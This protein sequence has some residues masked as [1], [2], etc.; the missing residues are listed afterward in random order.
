MRSHPSCWNKTLAQLGFRRKRRKA[1]SKRDYLKRRSLFEQLEARQMLSG[2]PLLDLSSDETVAAAGIGADNTVVF[3]S[4]PEF[5]LVEREYTREELG[6]DLQE[7]LIPMFVVETE[8]TQSGPKA[9]L[10]FNPAYPGTPP[11]TLQE[12]TLE[13]REF[14]N[15][16]E[17]YD[18]LIDIAEETFREQF[19]ADR[20]AIH[21]TDVEKVDTQEKASWL[22]ER[23]ANLEVASQA[24]GAEYSE[25]QQA[26]LDEYIMPGKEF[27]GPWTSDMHEA[28]DKWTALEANSPEQRTNPSV[29]LLASLAKRQVENSDVLIDDAERER[30]YDELEKQTQT[31]KQER[32]DAQDASALEAVAA[33]EATLRSTTLLIAK[34]LGADLKSENAKVATAAKK[35]RDELVA[36]NDPAEIAFAG[37]GVDQEVERKYISDGEKAV[38][39]VETGRYQF[40]DQLEIDLGD[41]QAM[42]QVTRSWNS[43]LSPLTSVSEA[44]AVEDGSYD[45]SSPSTN[46]GVDTSLHV[47]GTLGALQETLIRFGLDDFANPTTIADA[48]LQLS[49]IG[50]GTG[51]AEVYVWNGLFDGP[52]GGVTDWGE[53]NVSWNHIDGTLDLENS[54]SEFTQLS[55]WTAGTTTEVDVSTQL[56]RALLYGD[57]NG[58]G[59]FSAAGTDGDIEAFHLAVTNWDAYVAEYG[60]HANSASDLL[61]RTDGG[62]GDG[63]V[64]TSDIT[65]FFRRHGYSQGDY[66]L[67]GTVQDNENTGID[68]YDWA[69]WNANYGLTN[70]KFTQ[71]DGNFDGVVDA[72]DYDIWFDR[73]GE[74]NLTP[75]IPEVTVW[76]RPEDT[77]TDIEFAAQE[78][79]TLDGPTLV[80]NE[81]PDLALNKFSVDGSNLV[82]DYAVLGETFTDVKVQLYKVG[83]P[84]TLLHET[85]VQSGALG[86][87][88]VLISTS[89]LASIVEGDSVYAKVVGTPSSGTQANTAND[90]FDFEFSTASTQTVNSLDDVGM[91][92]LLRDQHTLRELILADNALGWF[93]TITFDADLFAEGTGTIALGDQDGNGINDQIKIA[94]DIIITGPGNHLLTIDSRQSS[95]AFYITDNNSSQLR[96]VTI[97]DLSITGGS[98]VGSGGALYNYENFTLDNINLHNNQAANVGGGLYHHSG[99]LTIHDSTLDQ[100]SALHGGGIFGF[101]RS[102]DSLD[103]ARSTFSYN[104]A[105]SSGGAF[106][107]KDIDNNPNTYTS[108]LIVNSTFSGNTAVGHTGG[109]RIRGG[110][111]VETDVKII[112][113]TV[114]GNTGASAGGISTYRGATVTLHN[115][116]V[117]GNTA[118]ND[119]LRHDISGPVGGTT[120]DPSSHNLIGV[121]YSGQG[122]SDGVDGNQIGTSATPL[123]PMLAPLDTYGL[124]A[125]AHVP[126][127]GS[128]AIDTGNDAIVLDYDAELSQS[129]LTQWAD[130]PNVGIAGV[131][132]DVGSASVFAGN[133]TEAVMIQAAL[134]GP[135]MVQAVTPLLATPTKVIVNLVEDELEDDLAGYYE[136]QADIS[137]R[138]ALEIAKQGEVTRIEFDNSVFSTPETIV[139]EFLATWTRPGVEKVD[140]LR[141]GSDVEI[142]GPGA[143]LLTLSGDGKTNVFYTG[144]SDVEI[145]GVTITDGYANYGG[146][147][148]NTGDLT[149]RDVRVTDNTAKY[150][151]G[152]INTVTWLGAISSSTLRIYDS[153]I[154]ENV[155]LMNN[156][157]YEFGGGGIRVG[158]DGYPYGDSHSLIVHNSTISTNEVHDGGQGGAIYVEDSSGN[159]H[160]VSISN[161]TIT[162]NEATYGAGIYGG[163][164]SVAS[165]IGFSD[166][167]LIGNT[168]NGS[169]A[170]S[171]IDGN[172]IDESYDMTRRGLFGNVNTNI[173]AGLTIDE[174]PTVAE[175]NL[176]PLQINGGP[177]KTHALLSGSVAIDAAPAGTGTDQRGFARGYDIPLHTDG[178]NLGDIGAFELVIPDVS[179][180]GVTGTLTID[181]AA[182]Q[183]DL[184]VLTVSAA[185]AITVNGVETT[186]DSS[187][188]ESISVL[189]RGGDDIIDLSAM[190]SGDF[191]LLSSVSVAGGDDNDTIVG[192]FFGDNI[193]GNAGN[194]VLQGGTGVDT[195]SGDSGVDTLIGDGS[196]TL[197]GGTGDDVYFLVSPSGSLAD[198]IVDTPDG[199]V[200]SLPTVTISAVAAQTGQIAATSETHAVLA[201]INGINTP[202]TN[203]VLSVAADDAAADVSLTGAGNVTW[204]PDS[205][206]TGNRDITISVK[207]LDAAFAA[208]EETLTA[209]V[210][211]PGFD[212]DNDRLT[213][214]EEYNVSGTLFDD[215]DTDGDLLGDGFET[216]SVNLD[217]NSSNDPSVDS[218]GDGLSDIQEQ[219]NATNPD[220]PDSDEDGTSDQDEIDQGSFPDDP[221]DNGEPVPDD[222]KVTLYVG[223]A[224]NHS[225]FDG[226]EQWALTVD[227]K[228]VVMEEHSTSQHMYIDV[229]KGDSFDV[230]LSWV[231]PDLT[232]VDPLGSGT[233][234]RTVDY[235][236]NGGIFFGATSVI[237]YDPFFTVTEIDTI[238]GEHERSMRLFKGSDQD[239]HHGEADNHSEGRSATAHI[240]E[241]NLVA[242]KPEGGELS[243]EDEVTKGGWL[244]YVTG[245]QDIQNLD[246]G[247]AMMNDLLEFRVD[248]IKPAILAEKAAEWGSRIQVS[249]LGT[250]N[251]LKFWSDKE[252]TI[253]F[254]GIITDLSTAHTFYA[255]ALVPSQEITISANYVPGNVTGDY[256]EIGG[257]NKDTVKLTS[258]TWEGVTDVAEGTGP[259]EYVVRTPGAN[260]NPHF[261]D[262]IMGTDDYFFTDPQGGYGIGIT[263]DE[264]DDEGK[265]GGFSFAPED[266][267]MWKFDEVAI[268]DISVSTS[269]AEYSDRSTLEAVFQDPL[270]N[271]SIL[272]SSV[273]NRIAG[274]FEPA[275]HLTADI[276]ADGPQ[277]DNNGNGNGM[278]YGTDKIEF[279]FLQNTK[280]IL[281]HVVYERI[282]E[283]P[284]LHQNL[285][286]GEDWV[287][288]AIAALPFYYLPTGFAKPEGNAVNESGTSPPIQIIMEDSPEFGFNKQLT[289]D[290]KQFEAQ[291]VFWYQNFRTHVAARTVGT[292]TDVKTYYYSSAM[293]NWTI[294]GSGN[295]YPE[296]TSAHHDKWDI[297]EAHARAAIGE[298]MNPPTIADGPNAMTAGGEI[299]TVVGPTADDFDFYDYQVGD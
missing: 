182:N 209:H 79:T 176:G 34:D 197:Q 25:L 253:E 299:K 131:Y 125:A 16:F 93:E 94:Q 225:G 283:Q 27:V 143:D 232:I 235:D 48:A 110:L 32:L 115:T 53:T 28:L 224:D 254:D 187:L 17:T 117:A 57:A 29:D 116:I 298:T 213:D 144:G 156:G 291:E 159:D 7:E 247:P 195:L 92:T 2:D 73:K 31:V 104:T 210:V 199:P 292:P 105:S 190:E 55:N 58:D 139:L 294:D 52:T 230:S 285:L 23:T 214:L 158:D 223:I 296:P 243:E 184:V 36:I 141:V 39:F 216:N 98:S 174:Q 133:E 107:Y 250:G 130:I 87:H 60:P 290:S 178:T 228:T 286:V 147:I 167:L 186:V 165:Y 154:S 251:K 8:Q 123:D 217:A 41:E 64:D 82:V 218:D 91:D 138:E 12:I 43:R 120:L 258:F 208:S 15:V 35:L 273:D 297:N 194:D 62:L 151:G 46:G 264:V 54:L 21:T 122:I 263:F 63:T 270:G 112:N 215:F 220:K 129:G 233:Y 239:R 262:P 192:S 118:T 70:A 67:D 189:G 256:F 249:T 274:N 231:G 100:N 242:I 240:P 3:Q 160:H 168:S 204:L 196:D 188:V 171:Q 259:Y 177:T 24:D 252:K 287:I 267:W 271:G 269:T 179:F 164:G 202:G 50:T 227:G 22:G 121:G 279:G 157:G 275:L 150:G 101:F 248:P 37:L 49:E 42:V 86:S 77:T 103:V 222:Q 221:S 6:E 47:D 234:T 14:G 1:S 180:D 289:W 78:H 149:L 74:D 172:L 219:E 84:D 69:V 260:E 75:E 59:N 102:A 128:P 127:P 111:G 257:S 146:G 56:Q 163:Y 293:L 203:V 142:I 198:T 20:I 206:V 99:K 276:I 152:G 80:V 265:W 145:S 277:A 113:T 169:T 229:E 170:A 135:T 19:L 244:P 126:L 212:T 40:S 153:E 9:L 278:W 33:R 207:D 161:S 61:A 162:A 295:L 266:G 95:R 241:V 81:Q 185:G 89:V 119:T 65:D 108:G 200:G 114:T 137:L 71:G 132:S 191:P 66:N 148:F 246:T 134:A 26:F 97:S 83:S 30:F 261:G 183:V 166:T 245:R 5:F 51:E 88:E 45:E 18:I 281:Q 136:G 237:V 155:V 106:I 282:A 211:L 96:D 76:V 284:V 38:S 90:Q 72:D 236:W 140:S 193:A 226:G 201:N 175:V 272:I 68:G 124:H 13:L 268:V 181:D 109:I 11:T 44:P 10:S 238:G 4:K 288:D 173:L 85:S 280:K 255:E 205:S